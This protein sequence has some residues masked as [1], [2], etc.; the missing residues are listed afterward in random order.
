M[1]VTDG[2]G[3]CPSQEF[4]GDWRCLLDRCGVEVMKREE[5]NCSGERFIYIYMTQ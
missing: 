3:I 1:C 2:C 4:V 5:K